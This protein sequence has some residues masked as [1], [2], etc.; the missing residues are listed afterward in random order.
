MT[1]LLPLLAALSAPAPGRLVVRSPHFGALVLVDRAPV[2]RVPLAPLPLSVGFHLVEATAPGRPRWG[3]LVFVV[4]GRDLAVDIQWLGDPPAARRVPSSA[5]ARE[6]APE[7]TVRLRADAQVAAAWIGA[8]HDT[9]LRLGWRLDGDRLGGGP[10]SGAVAGRA[11][12]DLVGPDRLWRRVQPAQETALRLDEAWLAWAAGGARVAA[13]RLLRSGPGG[14]AYQVDGAALTQAI[15]PAGLF[16]AGGRRAVAFGPRPQDPA[17]V[18][19]GLDAAW[20]AS[21]WQAAWL[22]HDGRH[23]SDAGVHWRGT[24]GELNL[25][26]RLLDG[27]WAGAGV[28]ARWRALDGLTALWG[29]VAADAGRRG[30]FEWRLPTLGVFGPAPQRQLSLSWGAEGST[31]P[32][33]WAAQGAIRGA[34]EDAWRQHDGALEGGW[35]RYGWQ[36]AL[37]VRGRWSA[38]RGP[39][40]YDAVEPAGELE[41]EGR[42]GSVGLGLGSTWL[43]VPQRYAGEGRWLPSLAVQGRLRLTRE[44]A[45]VATA[46]SQ[47]VHPAWYPE[48]DRMHSFNLGVQLR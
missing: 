19:A 17:L 41:R 31:A 10:W 36:A 30:P 9:D 3:R 13:G 44:L 47:A 16:L 23:H 22:W 7:P 28:T 27:S 39:A 35:R 26:G 37:R 38:G 34:P 14:V 29:R 40:V 21:R 6:P 20:G 5:P 42:W 12:N 18:T 48:G 15:G 46:Q 4:P 25:G 45:L 11:L 32:W 2:G 1:P 33:R 43:R 24:Q 8:A